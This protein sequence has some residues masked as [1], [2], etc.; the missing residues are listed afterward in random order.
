MALAE[1]RQLLGVTAVGL[2]LALVVGGAL[3]LR[4]RWPD[5]KEWS[6]KLVHIGSGAVVP[7]A[8]I[9]G[10]DRAI[11]LAAA[12]TATAL[13]SLNHRFRLLGAIEDVGRPSYGTIAYGA[14][15]SLLLALFWPRQPAAVAAGVLVMALGDG[16]AG[17]LGAGFHSPGWSLWGQRKSLLGTATMAATSLAVLVG[18]AACVGTATGGASP[19]LSALVGIA[20][21]ATLLEQVAV[22]GLDNFSVPVVTGLL[23]SALSPAG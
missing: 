3:L 15:I 16:M 8:W 1:Q 2:W 13:T 4:R 10:I 14:S 12:L 18:L 9:F 22:A 5:Q 7:L 19:T 21:V 17:L 6:R 11:A 20:L 23:W